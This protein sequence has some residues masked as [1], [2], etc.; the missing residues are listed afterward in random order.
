MRL[1]PLL[2]VMWSV[3]TA[4]MPR[5][6]E[7]NVRRAH[8]LPSEPCWPTPDDVEAL[9]VALDPGQH[10]SLRWDACPVLQDPELCDTEETR[11]AF[12]VPAAIPALSPWNQPMYGL[13]SYFLPDVGE[14]LSPLFVKDQDNPGPGCFSEFGE[15]RNECLAQTRNNA[16]LGWE[17][18]FTVFATSVAH[19]QAAVRFS[20]RHDLCVM[21]A[22]TGHDFLNRHSCNN[23][24]FIRTTMIKG[25]DWNLDD[26]RWPDGSVRLGAGTTFHEVQKAAAERGRYVSSGWAISVG[27]VGWSIGGGHGPFAPSKGMGVDNILEVEVVTASGELVVANAEQNMDLWWAVRGG[28]GSTWGVI[29]SITLRAH[30]TPEGGFVRGE[31]QWSG[32]MCS[33]GADGRGRLHNLLDGINSWAVARNEKWSGLTFLTLVPAGPIFCGATWSLGSQYVFSG[34]LAGEAQGGFDEI[35]QLD[36]LFEAVVFEGTDVWDL[37]FNLPIEYISPAPWGG[38]EV[39]PDQNQTADLL[40]RSLRGTK[41]RVQPH[42]NTS[43]AMWSPARVGG[44]AYG[45]VHH[46]R[47]AYPPGPHGEAVGGVPSVSVSRDTVASGEFSRVL[48]NTA[49]LCASGNQVG[50]QRHELYHDITGNIGSPQATNTSVGPDFREAIYHVVVGGQSLERMEQ[51]Y[52]PLGKNSYL[53]ESAYYMAPGTFGDRYW[54]EDNYRRLLDIKARYDPNAV[55]WCHHC[56]GDTEE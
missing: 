24:V 2:G 9:R 39:L 22:G 44:R 36:P 27:V 26:P 14:Q 33:T 25:Q 18:A 47:F 11:R 34:P 31:V 10:R 19:V 51:I 20:V 12:P 45:I 32:G 28:G 17:P 42:T 49:D 21:V 7:P 35:A 1:V 40:E 56:V 4:A 50:C 30:A 23:G 37:V 29:T 15:E 43:G 6:G 16:M 48:K 3:G 8:C 46:Q 55:F 41:G 52:Y 5:T 13:A 54:G 53:S 38:Q